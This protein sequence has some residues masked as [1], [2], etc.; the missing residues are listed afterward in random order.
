M[1]EYGSGGQTVLVQCVLGP[2]WCR[3]WGVLGPALKRED[4][5]YVTIKKA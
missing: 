1:I 5:A 4:G 3:V 2:V